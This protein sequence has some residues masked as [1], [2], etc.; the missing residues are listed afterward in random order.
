MGDKISGRDHR[1]FPHINGCRRG[2]N[3]HAA[4]KRQALDTPD[5]PP[6]NTGQ[7]VTDPTLAPVDIILC[8]FSRGT[9][10]DIPAADGGLTDG[11]VGFVVIDVGKSDGGKVFKHVRRDNTD[12]TIVDQAIGIVIGHAGGFCTQHGTAIDGDVLP[13]DGDIPRFT[14]RIRADGGPTDMDCFRSE[15]DINTG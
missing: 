1:M 15:R 7:G 3:S 12:V 2:R 10:G 5:T 6:S 4:D 8:G 11:D 9:Q 13:F 14:R